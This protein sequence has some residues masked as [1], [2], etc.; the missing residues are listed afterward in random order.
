MKKNSFFKLDYYI[1]LY[2]VLLLQIARCSASR[3]ESRDGEDEEAVAEEAD[4]SLVDPSGA[5][6]STAAP[7]K[8]K[9]ASGSSS[10]DLVSVLREFLEA[11]KGEGADLRRGVSTTG[12][13]TICSISLSTTCFQSHIYHIRYFE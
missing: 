10:G 1:F 11:D 7:A 13:I 12:K 6:S 9:K 4:D 2:S 8:K 3:S 5:G